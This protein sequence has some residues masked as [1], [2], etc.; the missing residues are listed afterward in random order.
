MS[1]DVFKKQSHTV[2]EQFPSFYRDEGPRFIAFVKSFYEWMEEEGPTYKSRRLL[3][4]RDIDLTEDDYLKHFVAKYMEGMPV[5]RLG[6]K[7]FLQKHILDIY[8]SKG[9][10]EGLR[11]L[12]R[13]LYGEEIDVYIPSRDILKASDGTWKIPK[14]LEVSYSDYNKN[15]FQQAITGAQSGATAIVEDYVVKLV[16]GRPVYAFFLSNI[17]GDFQ[18]YEPVIYSGLATIDAPIIFGSAG[19]LTDVSGPSGRAIGDRFRALDAYGEGLG[20]EVRANDL[21]TSGDGIVDFDLVF[22][23]FGYTLTSDVTV[24]A[25]ALLDEDGS[26]YILTELGEYFDVMPGTGAG[27]AITQISNTS[28]IFYGTTIIAPYEEDTLVDATFLYNQNILTESDDIVFAETGTDAIVTTG[29]G[30]TIND[31]VFIYDWE[32]L[33]EISVGTI[34]AITVTGTGTGYIDDVTVIVTES[35]VVE[36]GISDGLGGYWGEDA[37][38]EGDVVVGQD[39]IIGARM[40]DSG[41]GYAEG[42]DITLYFSENNVITLESGETI[43]AEDGDLLFHGDTDV[44][45]MSG[46][47]ELTALGTGAGDWIDTN[48]ML[49]ADKYIQDSFYYQEYSYDVKASRSLNRYEQPLRRVYHPAGVE[50]FGT[51]VMYGDQLLE[52][53]TISEVIQS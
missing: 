41:F 30:A 43:S 15:F 16:K 9:S 53:T 52:H 44:I 48:G 51:A 24:A 8:R 26:T 20:L 25:G 42:D 3:D 49:N 37:V 38:I 17:E 50:L 5:E 39:V 22:G 6:D 36:L 4:Y 29:S 2:P 12:F 14:Y 27:F 18:L 28:S 11:L 34:T 21:A 47:V 33:Q 35:L 31:D 13:F 45:T 32:D 19:F 7:R 46:T 10:I 1:R 40:F 23:G